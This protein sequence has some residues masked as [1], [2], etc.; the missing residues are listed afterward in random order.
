MTNNKVLVVVDMQNDFIDGAL[1]NKDAQKIVTKTAKFVSEWEGVII[2]TRYT[3][4]DD[5]LE[6]MEGKYLPVPHC[7]ENTEGWNV[8]KKIL[9]AATKNRKARIAYLNKNKFGAPNSLVAV[10]R[11]SYPRGEVNE[12]VFCGTCTDI[13]VVSNVLGVKNLTDIPVKVIPSLC[14]GLTPAKH[15]AAIEVM[16]SCQVEVL[17]D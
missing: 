15:K 12:V 11:N 10:L 5:Y 16:R 7:I 3:H 6:T 4:Y 1:A 2:F 9:D 14:A 17:D 8:N 13:C